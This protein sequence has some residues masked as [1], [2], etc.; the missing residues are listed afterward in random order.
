MLEKEKMLVS[1]I[2]SSPEHNMLNGSFYGGY[3]SVVRR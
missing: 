2:F 3:V 1:S